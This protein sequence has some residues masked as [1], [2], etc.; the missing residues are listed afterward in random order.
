MQKE[1]QNSEIVSEHAMSSSK[2]FRRFFYLIIFVFML[3]RRRESHDR[4]KKHLSKVRTLR[5]TLLQDGYSS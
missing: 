3:I 2:H 1:F 5:Q 4:S